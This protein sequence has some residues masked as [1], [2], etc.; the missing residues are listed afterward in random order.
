MFANFS[1]SSAGVLV[2]VAVGFIL[3]L[4]I[5]F[6]GRFYFAKKAES[7]LAEKYRGKKWKSPLDARN[8]YP[9]VDVFR[10]R[11]LYLYFGIIGTLVLTIGAFN[12]TT[13]ENQVVIPD[14]A[15]VLDEEIEIEVPRSAEPPP[16]PPPP[17][18][19]VIQEVPNEVVLEA[20]DVEFVDQSV[21]EHTA[22]EAPDVVVADKN[23]APPPPPPPPPPE[24]K[25]REIFKV[26]EEMPRFPGCEDLGTMAEKKACADKKMLEFIYANVRYPSIARENGIEGT[27]VVQFVVDVDGSIS[28]VTLARDIGAKCGE[29][30]VRIVNLMNDMPERWSPG[31]QRGRAVPVMFTLP[32]KFKLEYQ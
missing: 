22:I 26:V 21:T 6:A 25:V 16:P 13:Y 20:E 3:L 15:L 27:V 2:G 31:K 7:G 29:E 1:F 9:D 11:P 19:P 4:L 23:D 30:G 28:D 10:K 32:I 18:P 8:K 17:P 14:D 12:W 5:I 24:P